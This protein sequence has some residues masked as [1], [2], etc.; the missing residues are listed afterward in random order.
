MTNLISTLLC[1]F[2]GVVGTANQKTFYITVDKNVVVMGIFIQVYYI[3]QFVMEI[4]TFE[5]F[6]LFYSGMSI[7]PMSVIHYEMSENFNF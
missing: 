6:N 7:Y 2:E 4:L 5:I 1:G 3:F